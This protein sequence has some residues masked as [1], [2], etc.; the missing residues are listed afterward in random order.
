MVA[1]PTGPLAGATLAGCVVVGRARNQYPPDGPQPHPAH[2]MI[3]IMMIRIRIH[4][5]AQPQAASRPGGRL[6]GPAGPVGVG[7]EG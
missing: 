2:Q 4:H 3:R 6:P 1:R 5:Q 7:P